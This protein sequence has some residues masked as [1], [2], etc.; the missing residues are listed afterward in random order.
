[1]TTCASLRLRCFFAW[2]DFIFCGAWPRSVLKDKSEF[3]M[4]AN[5]ASLPGLCTGLGIQFGSWTAPHQP[6]DQPPSL[7]QF[8]PSDQSSDQESTFAPVTIRRPRGRPRKPRVSVLHPCSILYL[9]KVGVGG[10]RSRW[11]QYSGAASS[12]PVRILVDHFRV[13]RLSQRA[14]NHL[15]NFW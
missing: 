10:G 5:L 13:L 7:G 9:R 15:N 14:F 12:W 6:P 3:V 8:S 11:T 1:M 4:F 2:H